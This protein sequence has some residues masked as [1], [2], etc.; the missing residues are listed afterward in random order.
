[1]KPSYSNSLGAQNISFRAGLRRVTFAI[2]KLLISTIVLDNSNV[3]WETLRCGVQVGAA[4]R[5]A[6]ISHEVLTRR[7]CQKNESRPARPI[8]KLLISMI[9]SDNS[10]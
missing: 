4:V 10:S 2:P 8:P 7:L 1:M 6:S 9:I 3:A 5:T